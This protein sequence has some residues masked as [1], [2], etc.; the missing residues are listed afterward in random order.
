MNNIKINFHVEQNTFVFEAEE[1]TSS[2]VDLFFN[3]TPTKTANSFWGI[4]FGFELKTEDGGI[5]AY[6]VYPPPGV[7][8]VNTDQ[9]Y[10]ST[11]E[12]RVQDNTD[13]TLNV[14]ASVDGVMTEDS[15]TFFVGDISRPF[16]SWTKDSEGNWLPPVP[17]PD[18]NGM[19]Q[20]DE[21]TTSWVAV[22]E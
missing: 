8:Y 19:Y 14:W 7:I 13:Y 12:L 5:E 17:Y 1:V 16:P 3:V 20:W 2:K 10:L 9:N 4:G 22:E 6:G 18:D 11:K 21:S 15:L